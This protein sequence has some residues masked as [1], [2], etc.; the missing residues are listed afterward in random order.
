MG[1][2]S[3][4]CMECGHPLL[5][6]CAADE[7]IN[8][9]MTAGV[10][11]FSNGDRLSGEYDGYGR[12]DG[13]DELDGA[14]CLHR[15]CWEK[16][17]KPEFSKYGKGSASAPD[18]G[19]FFNDEHD[20]IDPYV[21]DEG[22]RAVRLAKGVELRKARQYDHQAREMSEILRGLEPRWSLFQLNSGE[23]LVG[24]K[25]RIVEKTLH[26]TREEVMAF[27]ATEHQAFLQTP[28]AKALIARAEELENISKAKFVA[29]LRA[30]GRYE[31]S[32][33]P[34][35]TYKGTG[36]VSCYT[37]T[38]RCTFKTVASFDYTDENDN[39]KAR[40]LAAQAETKRLNDEW[41]AAG[42]P[43]EWL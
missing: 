30:T 32:Y 37:V 14:A 2:Y 6:A 23:W 21:T 12:L 17:G 41:V 26:G 9:W 15:A 20:M 28:E 5:P 19:Y 29:D 4:L 10:A 11:L 24:D 25:L 33:C 18:Q 38:D 35:R 22:E 3:Y 1:F 42:Y 7:G 34:S 13:R 36:H 43:V 39:N 16:A 40:A 8:E 27:L 31:T